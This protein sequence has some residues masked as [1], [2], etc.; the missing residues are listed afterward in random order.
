M[1][2]AWLGPA[3][4]DEGG[5]PYVATQLLAGL[6]ATGME[7]DCFVAAEEA[8]LPRRLLGV[9]G[10]RLFCEAPRWR[11]GAW[12]SRTQ[13]GTFLTG[14]GARAL[15]QSRLARLLAQRHAER[16]YGVYYQFSQIE[17]GSVRRLRDALPPIVLHPE[18]HMAGELHW[19]RAEAALARR[20]ESGARHLAVRAM[21]AARAAT[22][23]RDVGLARL[24]VCPSRRFGEHLGA[25]YGVAAQRMAVV[26]NPIDL[27]RFAPGTRAA[28]GP[29]Y[30]LLFV[31]RMAVRKGVEMVVGLSERLA[32]LAGHV[33]IRVAGNRGLWTDYR[34]LLADLDGRVGEYVGPVAPHE[35]PDLYRA[36]HA[37]IAPSRYEPFG[38]TVGEGLACGLPAVAS[39]EVGAVEG[40]DARVSRV[41]PA[42]DLDGFE[43]A[44][45]ELVAELDRDGSGELARLARAEAQRAFAPATVAG[46]LARE[47]ERAA[48]QGSA[49]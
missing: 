45:R 5:V 29:P 17:L 44:V 48:G 31:A 1:R 30:T 39:D 32:D 3:P 19:H 11:P 14:Q 46:Q 47:L 22:Q 2:V 8:Q 23:R 37:V 38:L 43:A 24:V 36:S 15:A 7:I 28:G 13:L 12:Y 42:G 18:V 4:N 40:I 41:F 9:P 16:P 6:A 49:T 25:D 34:A 20:S 33:R 35:L 26:P 10:L 21:L 27:E